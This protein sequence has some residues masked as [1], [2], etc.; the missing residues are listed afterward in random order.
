MQIASDDPRRPDVVALLTEHLAEMRSC[1]PAC[2]VHAL[3]VDGLAAPAICFRTARTEEGALL[4]TG[5]LKDLGDGHAEIKSM[6]TTSA[7]RGCGI[8]AAMVLHLLALARS[9]GFERVSLETG[10]QD[11]FAP[12]RR[13]YLRQGFTE[14]GPY[15]DYGPDPNSAFFTLELV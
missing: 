9:A 11:H 1:S 8:G 13:L 15:A 7:A 10:A 12:A 5:A 3:D 2:S 6:R 14:C 4:A